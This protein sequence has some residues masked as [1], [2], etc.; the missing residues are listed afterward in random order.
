MTVLKVAIL[1]V[2]GIN[3]P[4]KCHTI[5]HTLQNLNCDLIAIQET[6]IT[7]KKIPEMKRLWPYESLVA[8]GLQYCLDPEW[9]QGPI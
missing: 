1:N 6:H 2:N 8:V 7:Q 9:K 3:D 5:F 4:A